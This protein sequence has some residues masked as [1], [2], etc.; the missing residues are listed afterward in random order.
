MSENKGKNKGEWSE[1]YIFFKLLS[2]RKIYVA[3]KDMNKL[4]NVFLNIISIIREE[5]KGFEYRYYTGDNVKITLNGKEVKI[6]DSHQFIKFMNKVWN[7]IKTSSSTTFN[8]DEVQKFLKSIYIENITSPAQKKTDYFGGTEDIVLDTVDYRSGVSRIMGFSCKSDIDAAA[9]LFNASSD[10]TNFIYELSGNI[11]D[12]IMNTFN[13]MYNEIHKNN[14]IQYTVAIG[15]RMDFLKQNKIDLHFQKTATALSGQNLVRCCGMEMPLLVSGLLKYFYY[16]CSASTKKA[17]LDNAV[18]YLA[19]TDYVN[20][21]FDGLYETY[22]S[23]VTTLLYSMFTGLKFGK[24]WSGKSDVNGGYI[25]VKRDGDVV[26][27]HSCIADE[28]KDF[29]FEKLNFEAPSCSRHKYM[30]I[31]KDETTGKY[32]LKLALQLRFKLMRERN[33]NKKGE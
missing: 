20:Y 4:E 13:S 16:E 11:N 10:N 21:G 28:F 3:D 27:F 24:I 29:L 23:K 17:S 14:K 31:Y 33:S 1:I 15:D 32:Y 18:K 9:T 5:T 8:D 26:A 2:D 30:T 25:V 12:D 19:E 7:M 6:V 22:R